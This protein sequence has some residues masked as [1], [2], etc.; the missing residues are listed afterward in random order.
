MSG[1]LYSG[2][3]PETLTLTDERRAGLC[4]GSSEWLTILGSAYEAPELAAAP[5]DA[6]LPKAEAPEW[7]EWVLAEVEEVWHGGVTGPR[8]YAYRDPPGRGPPA[9]ARPNSGFSG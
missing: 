3:K 6:R 7:G 4:I 9:V 8:P 1:S 2:V 5:G